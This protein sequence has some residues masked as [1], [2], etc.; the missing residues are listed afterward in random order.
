M[1][2]GF[3]STQD[4][5]NGMISSIETVS[6]TELAQRRQNLRH[7]RRAK[8]LQ[9]CWRVLAVSG[10]AGG[11]VWAATSPAWVIQQPEQIKISGNRSVSAQ[12]V[13]SL[14]PITYP[15][16]LLR[17]EPRTIA[18]GLKARMPILEEVTVNRQLF[19]LFSPSLTVQLKERYPVA[20]A[21]PQPTAQTPEPQSVKAPAALNTKTGLLDASGIWIPLESY[22]SVNQ[23]LK[24]P[25][26]KVIGNPDQYRPFWSKLYQSVSQ[27]PVKILE[28]DWRDSTNL[29]L[30]TEL[31]SVHFGAY[32]PQFA[33][34]LKVLDKLRKLPN[35]LSINQISYIDLK[36]PEAPMVQMLKSKDP[37][38][39]DM[40]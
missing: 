3:Y 37:V 33:D 22:T 16:S 26:L 2:D 6:S 36:S 38:K 40:P 8:L 20:I 28:I 10:L 39:L 12:K 25:E 7:K 13:R 1:R 31:G 29:V 19:P 32:S 35:H 15:E 4:A 34:Q 23:S 21:L 27:S 24:L 30:K 17:L 5:S 14:L 18:D 11:M 9:T